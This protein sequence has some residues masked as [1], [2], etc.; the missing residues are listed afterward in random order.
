MGKAKK[1]EKKPIMQFIY[2][3]PYK[4]IN[5]YNLAKPMNFTEFCLVP[6]WKTIL[7]KFPS[8]YILTFGM[9][10][11][12][13]LWRQL[14]YILNS[15]IKWLSSLFNIQYFLVCWQ[16]HNPSNRTM[17]RRLPRMRKKKRLPTDSTD[18]VGILILSHPSIVT[19]WK[20]NS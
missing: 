11:W 1:K 17:L 13:T 19:M 4:C 15:L 9:S 3:Y 10:M 16:H 2:R 5:A 14:H 7:S 6:F 18:M 20:S 8:T 12:M